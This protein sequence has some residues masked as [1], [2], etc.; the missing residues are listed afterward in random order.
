[1]QRSTDRIR[2]SH[3]GTLPREAE[4]RDRVASSAR[5]SDELER[6]VSEA[7]TA[8]VAKQAEVG[9]DIGNDG[10]FAKHEGFHRYAVS[11]IGGLER[12]A[13]EVPQRPIDLRDRQRFPGYFSVAPANPTWRL[14][15]GHAATA[16]PAPREATYVVGPLNYVGKEAAQRD[17]ERLKEALAGTDTAG[18]EMVPYLAAVAPGTLEHLLMNEYYPD[19]E[20]M[21]SAIAD[22]LHEEYKVIADAGFILQIDDPDLPDGWQ[23]NPE[24]TLDEYR[25]YAEVRVEALNQALEGIPEEQVRLHV[26]WGSPLGPHQSDIAL[27]DI[28]DIVLKVHAQCYSVEAANP[29]HEHEWMVW[30]DTKLPA[31][32]LLMPGVIGHSSLHIEHPELVAQRLMR[33]AEVVGR[34]NVIAGTD[35]GLG[36]RVPHAEI[37]WAKFASLVEGARLASERLWRQ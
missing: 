15:S 37:A 17:V 14:W 25:R 24:M 9:I 10:E 29:V 4:F 33:F 27:A 34:E 8:V 6:Y 18:N 7:V 12:R 31:G 23:V 36:S 3:A 28:V 21:L 20:S 19:E 13:S 32:K 5:G 1:M 26:C 22:V 30:E 2:V 35:C 11:R 16:A